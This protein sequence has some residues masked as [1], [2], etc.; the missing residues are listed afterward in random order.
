M[1]AKLLYHGGAYWHRRGTGEEE[2]RL[3]L[4][5]CQALF[6]SRYAEISALVGYDPWTGWFRDVAWDYTLV[7]FDK[8]HARLSLLAVADAD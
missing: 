2:K 1:L 8:R 7:L 3:A 4:D 5:F 6:E